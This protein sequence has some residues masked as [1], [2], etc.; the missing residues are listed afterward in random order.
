MSRSYN[1]S[2]IIQSGGVGVPGH[3]TL[4]PSAGDVTASF[5]GKFFR[6]EAGDVQPWYSVQ[7]PTYTLVKATTFDI[8]SNASYAGRYSVYSMVDINDANYPSTFANGSTTITVNEI[9][10]PAAVPSDAFEGTV[11]NIS[12]FFIQVQGESPLVVPPGVS[13]LNR[14]LELIGRNVSPWAESYT[15]NIVSTV[16]NFAAPT[17][18]STPFLGQ[19]WYDSS[20]KRLNIWNGSAWAS[21]GVATV[22]TNE[23]FRFVQTAASDTWVITHNLNLEAP[24]VCLMQAFVDR[25]TDGFKAILPSDTVFSSANSLTVTFSNPETGIILIRA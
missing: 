18:P 20:T 21:F 23:T 8:V 19:S 5:H 6:N 25:G 17:A 15:Q 16:Q 4:S 9:I 22:G 13:L 24:Y 10:G 12:T 14:P 3:I 1:I 2:E 11:K 7:G